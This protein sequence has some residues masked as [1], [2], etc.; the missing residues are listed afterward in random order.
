MST[1]QLSLQS[2]EN[3]DLKSIWSPT[4]EDWRLIFKCQDKDIKN[5][6]QIWSSQPPPPLPFPC[7]MCR[8]EL[9]TAK[10]LSAHKKIHLLGVTVKCRRCRTH[11]PG[12]SSI[13]KFKHHRCIY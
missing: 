10:E 11:F 6:V 7:L 2:Q 13:Y 1:D 12:L 4:A 3:N 5:L 8:D 9:Q